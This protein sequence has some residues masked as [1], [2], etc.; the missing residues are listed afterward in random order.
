MGGLKAWRNNVRVKETCQLSVSGTYH[1][2]C[3]ELIVHLSSI[4]GIKSVSHVISHV[5]DGWVVINH[6]NDG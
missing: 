2:V 5:I 6:V 3:A 1:N 4:L